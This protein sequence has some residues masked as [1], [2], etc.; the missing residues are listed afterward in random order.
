[1]NRRWRAAG[2]ALAVAVAGIGVAPA[3]ADEGQARELLKEMSDY[4][5]AQEVL[6]FTYDSDIEVVTADLQKLAFASTGTVSLA[7]PDKIRVTRTGGFVDME[8]VFDGKHFSVLGKDIDSYTQVE[9]D[10]T[11]DDLVDRL[12][13]DY[14]IAAP[15]ADLLLSDVYDALMDNVTDVKDLGSGV[16]AGVECN[17]LAFRTEGVDWEIWIALGDAPYPCRYAV[18]SK[19]M[20]LGPQYRIEFRD[21]KTGAEVAVDDFG[22]DPGSAIE[23]DIA[24]LGGID[25]VPDLTPEGEDQ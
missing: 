14:G 8:M 24:D 9:L 21:W 12:R 5:A 20:A 13:I 23:V 1:M 10:G 6:S 11:I 18:T 25:G 19:L 22:F 17:H 3:R 4:L 15:G 16:I 7:R 2:V